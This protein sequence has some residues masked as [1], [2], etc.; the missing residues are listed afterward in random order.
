VPLIPPL[1]LPGEEPKKKKKQPVGP[2]KTDAAEDALQMHIKLRAVKTLALEDPLVQQE[3]ANAKL[4]KKTD[5]DQREAYKRYYVLL[6]ARMLKIDPTIATGLSTRESVSMW[7]EYQWRVTPTVPRDQVGMAQPVGP[8]N[9]VTPGGGLAGTPPP[10]K[11][12]GA[13]RIGGSN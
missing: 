4:P 12:F 13:A 5:Y 8:E 3:L 2:S 9:Y 10:R 6:Y 11:F 1:T 7:R